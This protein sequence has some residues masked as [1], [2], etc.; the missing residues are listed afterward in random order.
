MKKI[1][2]LTGAALIALAS[3]GAQAET[4]YAVGVGAAYAP[5]YV[6]SDDYEISALPILSVEWESEKARQQGWD[7]GLHGAEISTVSGI[8]VEP[9][10]YRSVNHLVR[11]QVGI[12]YDMGRDED[13]N[14]DEGD[15]LNGLGDID[16]YAT[17][18]IALSYEPANI[19]TDNYITA[20]FV[21]EKDIMNEAD[22]ITATATIEAN[23]AYDERT[24]ISHGPSITW[25]N[26]NYTQA[27]YGVD[28]D[29]A[30]R[31][32]YRTYDADG[33]FHDVGYGV[34]VKHGYNENVGILVSANY[35]R[36]LGDASDSQIVDQEGTD[37]QMSIMTGMMYSF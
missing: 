35:N 29:Q 25:A 19:T 13:A 36:L 18:K 33:G 26:D 9:L 34:T 4:T 31:S 10:R 32:G 23:H 15:A 24:V 30:A 17:A 2:L 3:N 21:A 28:G 11:A 22:G 8:M 27:Y 20:S 6:G 5:D 12:G 7:L 37:H 16:G 14:D 1:V